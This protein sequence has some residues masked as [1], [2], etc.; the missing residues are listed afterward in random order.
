MYIHYFLP[1]DSLIL[2]LIYINTYTWIM[3]SLMILSYDICFSI[4][5]PGFVSPCIDLF[6]DLLILFLFIAFFW[7]LLFYF[8]LL[9]FSAFDWPIQI[10]DSL[11][12]GYGARAWEVLS[13]APKP[14]W[15][16]GKADDRFYV[17]FQ[18]CGFIFSCMNISTYEDECPYRNMSCI[19][20]IFYLLTVWFL[21]LSI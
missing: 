5:S 3:L 13:L 6:Y 11:Y 21:N 18:A 15:L 16:H 14:R 20:I 2:E 19:Y 4:L 12:I 7:T 1:F 8:H 9:D 17:G 10:P